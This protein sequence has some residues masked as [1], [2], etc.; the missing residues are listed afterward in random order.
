[1]RR[2]SGDWTKLAGVRSAVWLDASLWCRWFAVR[3]CEQWVGE[4]NCKVDALR[5]LT[6]L[7]LGFWQTSKSV[8]PNCKCVHDPDSSVS[9]KVIR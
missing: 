4:T 1:M 5:R 6:Y 3:A 9:L 8:H 7:A 2:D